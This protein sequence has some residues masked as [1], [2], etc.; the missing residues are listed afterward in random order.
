MSSASLNTKIM[1][2]TR[3]RDNLF[4]KSSQE[5]SF[6]VKNTNN[7]LDLDMKL[8]LEDLKQQ[9][10]DQDAQIKK[11]T[12]ENKMKANL[13]KSSGNKENSDSAAQDINSMKK[14]IFKELIVST[15]ITNQQQEQQVKI[16][17]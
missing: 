1:D 10:Q 5:Q 15:G 7:K 16:E 6:L 11:L 9:V 17:E 14:S 13:L 2:L 3:E 8:Q 12:S 4:L